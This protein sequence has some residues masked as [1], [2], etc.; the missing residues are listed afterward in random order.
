MFFCATDMQL[1]NI[2]RDILEKAVRLRNHQK[3]MYLV[4]F[5]LG[6]ATAMQVAEK[7]NHER[8]YVHMRLLEL[9]ERGL[10]RATKSGRKKLFE[11]VT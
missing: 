5:E 11:V 6:T 9:E 10:V 3:E 2:P 7:V 4:L 1:S 8:A